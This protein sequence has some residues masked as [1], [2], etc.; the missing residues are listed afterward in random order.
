MRRRRIGSLEVSVVGIGGNSF[1]TDFFGARCDQREVSRTISAALDVGINLVDTAEE[2]SIPSF[3]G[4]GH[5]EELIGA[6]LRDRRDEA[7]IATKFL[8]TSEHDPAERGA[9]R[10]VAAAEA[11][12]RRLGTDRIDLFQQHRPDPETPIDELLE[13]LDRLVLDGKVRE[14]GCCNFPGDMISAA[15]ESAARTGGRA[16]RSCQVQYSLLERP[17]DDVLTAVAQSD[18]PILAYFPLASG[19]LTGKYRRG[20][21]PPIDSRLGA[22]GTVSTMLRDGLMARRP[23]LSEERLTTVERLSAFA[24]E[25]GHSL[26]ELAISWL[27]SQ[28]LVGAVITGVTKAEQAIANAAASEWRLNAE[29]IA[30]VDDIVANE[31]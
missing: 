2:Y 16:F 26:L 23:P 12:L 30:R 4:D 18:L 21:A 10:I 7:I 6:A 17:T 11:S 20:E 8:N 28:P 15:T 1:G 22:G 25:R 24:L 14:I 29:D 19:L 27:V 3:L 5:S 31:A 13:A 9:E